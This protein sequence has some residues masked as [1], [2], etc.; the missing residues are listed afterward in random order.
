MKKLNHYL[1]AL[2]ISVSFVALQSCSKDDPVPEDDQEEVGGVTLTF[3]EVEREA[4]GDHY[5]Y[6]DITGAETETVSFSGNPLLPPVGAHLDLEEGK[7]YRLSMVAKDFAGRETQQ[8]FV[9]R[10]D[11]HQVFLLGAPAGALE[12]VYA[13]RKADN[14][15]VNV[16][17][18]GYLTVLKTSD[19]FT[20]RY[21]LRHLNPGVKAGI[22]A[23]DWNN[24]NFT[25]FSGENDLDLKVNLHL[26]HAG[27][28]SH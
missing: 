16:G 26:I 2:L 25:K 28:H 27:D 1:V 14:T 5:H 23:A 11:I 21:V 4:H 19:S 9:E 22:T 13:D 8:T 18:T 7:T 12:Y 6:N 15:K 24:V 17:V 10:D 3:T 20:F